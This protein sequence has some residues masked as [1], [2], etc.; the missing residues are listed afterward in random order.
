MASYERQIKR[1]EKL[2]QPDNKL[3]SCFICEFSDINA[4][5]KKYKAVNG[6]AL[7][8]SSEFP[9]YR[10]ILAWRTRK[11]IIEHAYLLADRGAHLLALSNF[12]EI[13]RSVAEGDE[14]ASAYQE[15]STDG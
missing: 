12:S 2:K 5:F 13:S 9:P 3:L 14:K 6:K 1:W 11:C 8:V 15:T 10:R 7:T 4:N